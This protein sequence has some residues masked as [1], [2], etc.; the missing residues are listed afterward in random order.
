MA[1]DRSPSDPLQAQLE[2]FWRSVEPLRRQIEEF[3]QRTLQPLQRQL[4]HSGWPPEKWRERRLE[5]ELIAE[6]QSLAQQ[7]SEQESVV[8]GRPPKVIPHWD[9]AIADL[10]D[11][12]G[13][14]NGNSLLH[15][16]RAARARHVLL[17][18]KRHS[19]RLSDD[20]EKAKR[21]IRD[22]LTPMEEAGQLSLKEFS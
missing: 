14:T 17:F 18:L 8:A 22:R 2:K 19:V 20:D 10:N 4:E 9:E 11:A 16:L 5:R 6:E 7:A 12:L 13:K 1:N 3:K 21:Y 15:R